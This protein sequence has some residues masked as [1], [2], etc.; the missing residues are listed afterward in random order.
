MNMIY[1]IRTEFMLTIIQS[2]LSSKQY[3]QGKRKL[4]FLRIAHLQET[5]DII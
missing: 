1:L 3:E 2:R 4:L 5:L